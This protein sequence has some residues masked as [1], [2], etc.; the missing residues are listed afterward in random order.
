MSVSLS[1]PA[2]VL[3]IG[4]RVELVRKGS[5]WNGDVGTLTQNGH[6]LSGVRFDNGRFR[7]VSTT[8][9]REFR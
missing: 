3:P 9:L 2:R 1:K 4:T 8:V 6:P 7:A 5:P